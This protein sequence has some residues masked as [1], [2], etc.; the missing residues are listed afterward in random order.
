MKNKKLTIVLALLLAF[1]LIISGCSSQPSTTD[2]PAGAGDYASLDTYK[3]PPYQQKS[4]GVNWK[5][6]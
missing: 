2:Q 4:L 1:A 6:L 5:L 3:Q